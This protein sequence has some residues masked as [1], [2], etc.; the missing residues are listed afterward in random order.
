MIFEVN[1]SAKKEGAF[2]EYPFPGYRRHLSLRNILVD[3]DGNIKVSD[4]GY[5]YSLHKLDKGSE[6]ISYFN[7]KYISRALAKGEN[8][9]L[10]GDIYSLGTVLYHLITGVAPIPGSNPREVIKQRLER[11][12]VSPDK[13]R[14]EVPEQVSTFILSM[15]SDDASDR[16]SSF[17][18]VL[19]RLEEFSDPNFKP[20]I[21]PG[22]S[23]SSN[24]DVK[25]AAL[26]SDSLS[27]LS[28]PGPETATPSGAESGEAEKPSFNPMIIGG[29]AAAIVVL[30]LLLTLGGGDKPDDNDN[31]NPP[32][33]DSN[34][35]ANVNQESDNQN[36]D[37]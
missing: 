14:N 17:S 33:N 37:A 18:D 12:P 32:Q 27:E 24:Q 35:T 2:G 9:G 5:S 26:P 10:S 31:P 16:P 7:P 4:F 21:S 8:N 29:A 30:L 13:V 20:V 34:Q 22:Y 19:K 11:K 25:V 15:M 28:L 6:L 3:R 36:P 1:Q 23:S